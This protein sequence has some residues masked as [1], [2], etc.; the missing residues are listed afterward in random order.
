MSKQSFNI[1]AQ[2]DVVERFKQTVD[3]PSNELERFMRQRIKASAGIGERINEIDSEIEE[4]EE[5]IDQLA[6]KKEN[7]RIEKETLIA[8]RDQEDDESDEMERFREVADIRIGENDWRKPED[9]Q[10]YWRRELEKSKEELWEEV[11]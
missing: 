2:S 5:E 7:L 6:Q 9:I 3:T 4:I 8:Q 1:Y 10:D 11:K